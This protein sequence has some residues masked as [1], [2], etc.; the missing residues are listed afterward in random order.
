L[1]HKDEVREGVAKRVG[2]KKEQDK[3]CLLALMFGAK[4]TERADNAIPRDI[5]VEKAR[6]IYRDRDFAAIDNNVQQGRKVILKS[7]LKNRTTLL[8]KLRENP[9]VRMVHIIQGVE[10][11]AIRAAIRL[12]PDEIVLLMHDGFVTTRAIDVQALERHIFDETGY[13]VC[14]ADG[15]IDLP[16]DLEFS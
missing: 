3:M 11:Q 9:E 1:T 12:Y 5:G 10:A 6:M 13:Q 15:I 16:A 2:I 8:K 14:M 4:T 7:C